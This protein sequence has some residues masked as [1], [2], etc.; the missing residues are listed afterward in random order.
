MRRL[1]W[2]GAR[3]SCLAPACVPSSPAAW[4][5]AE[6]TLSAD[7]WLQC[8]VPRPPGTQTLSGNFPL[9]CTSPS[10]RILIKSTSL[11]QIQF[12][13]QVLVQSRWRLLPKDLWH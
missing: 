2:V 12:S 6:V 13:S 1:E 4:S 7:V 3:S 5:G 11:S 8:V 10:S 9:K